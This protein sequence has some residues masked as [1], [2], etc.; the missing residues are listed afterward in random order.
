[1]KTVRKTKIICTLG[2]ATDRPGVLKALALGGMDVARFN[3]SHGTHEEHAARLD[4]LRKICDE[5]DLPIA[6]MLDTKGPEIRIKKFKD[7]SVALETGQEFILS[8]G[9]FDGDEHRVAITFDDLYKDVRPGTRILIDDGIIEMRVSEVRG[10]DIVCVVENGGTVSDRKGVNVP[11]VHLSLP[12]ISEQDKSDLLFGIEKGFD[13]V[14][15]SFTRTPD[16][17]LE[18]RKTL[19]DNGGSEIRVI[20]KIENKEGVENISDII[21]VSDGVMVARGDMGVEIPFEDVPSIQKKMIKATYMAGKQVI[22]ATQMLDSMMKNPR[23]TRAEAADVANAVYDGTSAI[24]LSGETAAG[25][26]P[27]EALK[28]M[29]RVALRTERDIDYAKR[30]KERS[31]TEA[32]DITNAIA[33]ATCTTAIDLDAAAIVSVSSSGRTAAMVAKYRPACRIVGCTMYKHVWRRMSLMW[34]VVP[35]LMDR[36]DNSDELFENAMEQVLK[37]DLVDQGELVVVTAGVPLGVTGT[38]NQI[39]VMVAGNTILRGRGA[40]GGSVSA[41]LCVV[42]SLDTLVRTFQPG[43][44]IVAVDTDK[45][46]LPQIRQA[47]GLILESPS[48]NSHGVISGMSL[49]IPV[50]YS[51]P[52]ATEILRSGSYITMD[53]TRGTVSVAKK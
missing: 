1:M 7:G 21:R 38:T 24:M 10:T 6:A 53:P 2:S 18:I 17:I 26:Y 25:A 13:Y 11:D 8:Q 30:L 28:A 16:D 35:L 23:P 45:D 48:A 51:A 31:N 12:F 32:P 36:K 19:E 4:A 50:I 9:D 34:G 20:A 46:M 33:H 47:S 39:R 29:A 42:D 27:V 3:F 44:I 14:A 40:N 22:T 15:A 5:E 43:D 52:H 49:D 41:N 37:N